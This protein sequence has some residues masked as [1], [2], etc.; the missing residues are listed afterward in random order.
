MGSERWLRWACTGSGAGAGGQGGVQCLEDTAELSLSAP[1]ISDRGLQIGDPG[2]GC[3]H[4]DPVGLLG[5][6]PAAKPLTLELQV[7]LH[8]GQLALEAPA[9]GAQPGQGLLR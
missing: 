6:T 9:G 3:A 8:L 1:K 7:R 2:P 4:G 5:G